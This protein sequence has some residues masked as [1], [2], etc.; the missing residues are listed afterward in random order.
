MGLV[1][2]NRRRVALVSGVVALIVV[3]TLLVTSRDHGDGTSLDASSVGAP[4]TST[5]TTTE[6]L[7]PSTL[8]AT[9]TALPPTPTTAR[10]QVATK[11]SPSDNCRWMM[12][13][14]VHRNS[15]PDAHGSY[16]TGVTVVNP[17]FSGHQVEFAIKYTEPADGETS[18]HAEEA[19][20]ADAPKGAF[21]A[22]VG[23]SRFDGTMTVTA[24]PDGGLAPCTSP[25]VPVKNPYGSSSTTSS[26]APTTTSSTTTSTTVA[27]G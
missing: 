19:T 16:S 18:K 21:F 3:G 26:T 9:T 11:A 24:L 20:N 15:G 12:S 27:A 17:D 7:V 10:R 2:G 1:A 25:T 6:A 22:S 5:T 4:V 8:A 14:G 23:I 13:G